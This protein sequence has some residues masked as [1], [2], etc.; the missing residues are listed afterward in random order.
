MNHLETMRSLKLQTWELEM[1]L[2]RQGLF[3]FRFWI[4][5]GV[6]ALLYIVWWYALDKRRILEILLF[7]SLIAVSRLLFD[8]WGT[9]SGRWAY[10]TDLVPMGTI[11]IT[12]L[13]VVPVTMMLVYQ[14]SETW[15]SYLLSTAVVQGIIAFGFFPLQMRLG[16]L[17]I[18]QWPLLG[19]FLII[20]VT[21]IIMRAVMH[22]GLRVERAHK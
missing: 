10:V 19:S 1:T 12:D 2:W 15:L 21:A 4:A 22:F 13:I 6:I 20:L 16:S 11:S 5:V 7:G 3:T 17:H 8:A 18:F 9:S 14:Y